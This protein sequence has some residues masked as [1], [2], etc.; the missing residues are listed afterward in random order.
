MHV[1]SV[2]AMTLE[3][4]SILERK[5]FQSCLFTLTFFFTSLYKIPWTYCNSQVMLTITIHQLLQCTLT[6]YNEICSPP[7][8][9]YKQIYW[10]HLVSSDYLRIWR[11]SNNEARQECLLNNVCEYVKEISSCILAFT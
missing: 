3:L 8:L 10:L 4:L 7:R 6:Y 1:A 9:D 5:F 2:L 11:V